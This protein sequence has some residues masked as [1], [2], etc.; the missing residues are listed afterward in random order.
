MTSSSSS[1]ACIN[2]IKFNLKNKKIL[3]DWLLL[4]MKIWFI[5]DGMIRVSERATNKGEILSIDHGLFLIFV[6]L[7]DLNFKLNIE[8]EC[9]KWIPSLSHLLCVTYLGGWFFCIR[10]VR[11]TKC[12][13]SLSFWKCPKFLIFTPT[14]VRDILTDRELIHSRLIVVFSLLLCKTTVL[15]L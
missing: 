7:L 3:H 14:F 6:L 2:H 12:R 9:H 4:G 10:Y 5:N 1:F 11:Y 8:I 15:N 13:K